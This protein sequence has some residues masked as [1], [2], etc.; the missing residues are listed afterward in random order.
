VKL[1]VKQQ[2]ESAKY[3]DV[4][5]DGCFK[6]NQKRGGDASYRLR[7]L[8]DEIPINPKKILDYGS[9]QGGWIQ[10]LSDKFPE[11]EIT[12]IDIS[13]N[14]IEV[15]SR[16]FP[17][18]KFLL[19]D[20]IKAPFPD[21]SFDLIFSYHVL[22][23]VWDLEKSVF[24][25]T[26][27]LKK[28]GVLCVIMPCSNE[29]SFE[30]KVTR[31]VDKGKEKSFDGYVRFYYSYG[32]NIRRLKS[33]ETIKLLSK[34]DLIIYKEYFSCQFWGA[35]DWMLKSDFSLL[36]EIFDY[37][38]GIN[39]VAKFKLLLYRIILMS[40]L[41]PTKL[42]SISM[43]KYGSSIGKKIVITIIAPLKLLSAIFAKILT[44]SSRLEWR[45]CKRSRN[46]STQYL[47]FVKNK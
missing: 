20:G 18:H 7:D 3:F 25:L 40:L 11:A 33:T 34:Y 16:L 38:R 14:G 29:N 32:A 17:G 44:I 35:I 2:D 5:F 22:D 15:A 45:L 4:W 36:K 42:C 31:L 21:N 8:L 26:R 13:E 43:K 39:L 19:F 46:G 47:I 24:D 6:I 9:G 12:G 1:Q 27:L 37:K 10:L 30:E 28:G 41:I 23:V